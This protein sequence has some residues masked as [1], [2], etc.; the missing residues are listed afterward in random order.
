MPHW[1]PLHTKPYQN[2]WIIAA[3]HEQ[4]FAGGSSAFVHRFEPKFPRFKDLNGGVVYEVPSSMVVLVAT[5]VHA[6]CYY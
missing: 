6:I 5:A 3:L 2:N 1:N 4:F